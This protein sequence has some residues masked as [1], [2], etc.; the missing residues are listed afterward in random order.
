MAQLARGR[1]RRKLVELER[2]LHGRLEEYHR[3]LLGMQMSRIEAIK[4]DL[5]E[6]D[7]RLRTKLAP[8]SQQ[9]HLLKQIPGMD[10]VIAATII[11]EIGVDMTAFA[12]AAHLAS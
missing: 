11:A 6:L 3:F 4:A 7:K 9:M 2:A 1:M 8:Y 5:G 10:W 12:S